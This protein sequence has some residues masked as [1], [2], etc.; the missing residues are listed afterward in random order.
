M[1]AR[2]V[3]EWATDGSLFHRLRDSVICLA[4]GKGSFGDRANY[5]VERLSAL[6]P[7]SFPEELQATFVKIEELRDISTWHGPVRPLLRTSH[8]RPSQRRELVAAI[9]SLYEAM[10][11]ARVRYNVE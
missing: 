1:R 8:L 4:Q 9:F 6:T 3:E 11:R 7:H 5:A 2:S 10:L